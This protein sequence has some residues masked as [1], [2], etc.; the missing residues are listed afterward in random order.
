[1]LPNKR[2]KFSHIAEQEQN[3]IRMHNVA[4][5]YEPRT[6]NGTSIKTDIIAIVNAAFPVLSSI[7]FMFQGLI[8]VPETRKV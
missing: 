5:G 2:P 8:Q 7:H 6:H 3:F 4:M 1:M